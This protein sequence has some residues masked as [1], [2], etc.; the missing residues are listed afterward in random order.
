MSE[1]DHRRGVSGGSPA[2]S[3]INGHNDHA[4][5]KRKGSSSYDA[6][7]DPATRYDY[8]PPRRHDQPHQV[9]DRVLSV[10]GDS[11]DNGDPVHVRTQT[12]VGIRTDTEQWRQDDNRSRGEEN[13]RNEI[14]DNR[15]AEALQQAT[16]EEG[17]AAVG[18]PTTDK[19][20]ADGNSPQQL[21]ALIS[22]TINGK[23]KRM[24]SNRTK[25]GCITCRK[26]KKKCD[27]RQ[28]FCKY[29]A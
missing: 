1:V 7:G 3:K 25:T 24:F 9:A 17:N 2:Y 4:S 11:K 26:R 23:R 14:A 13:S 22:T 28:P 6:T 18:S 27:E 29:H 5:K 20:S 12:N 16:H 15:M 10:L 8:S 21:D 19:E